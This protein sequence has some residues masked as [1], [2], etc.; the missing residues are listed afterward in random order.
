MPSLNNKG[1]E[2]LVIA[3]SPT[4][5]TI[6]AIP[7]EGGPGSV[8]KATI[9]PIEKSSVRY[10]TDK[11]QTVSATKGHLVQI[12]S[13]IEVWGNTDLVNFRSH[14]TGATSGEAEVSYEG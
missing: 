5:L 4:A 14:R 1:S 13:V 3:G 8:L 11:D 7:D 10:I 12:G 6:P 2:K 9:G